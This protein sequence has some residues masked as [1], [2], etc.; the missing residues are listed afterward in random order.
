M[1]DY[2]KGTRMK[3]IFQY[4]QD[5]QQ[6]YLE[7]LFTFLRCKSVSSYNDGIKE[8]AQLL[9]EIM[10]KSGIQTAIYPTQGN[11]VVY[12]EIIEDSAL[13]TMLIYGHY[14]VQPPEPLD[15]WN[16]PPFEPTI[17][18]GK[19]YCRGVSDDKSQLYTHIKA[20][21][22]WKKTKGRYPVNVKFLFEGEEEI[23]SPNL[24]PFVESHKELLSCDVCFYS[25]S[26]FHENGKPQINL[27]VKGLCYVEITIE[28]AKTDMHSMM[29]TSIQN[30]AWRLVQLLN[31]MYDSEG[32][33][34]IEGFYD[35]VRPIS[36]LEIEAVNKIPV[37]EKELCEVYGVREFIHGPHSKNFY[38]NL[39]F[40]PT[41]N[42]SGLTSGY[43]GPG[44]KTVLPRQASVKIDMRL[45][46]DQDPEKILKALRLHLNRHGFED[47]KMTHYGMVMP[48]R[49]RIDHLYVS[50]AVNAVK[51][52]FEEEP[53]LFPGIGGVAPDFVFTG[54]INVPTIVIPYAA[55]DQKNHAPNESM[56][57]DGFIKGL[58]TSAALPYYLAQIGRKGKQE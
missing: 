42:I 28:N 19:I 49:T 58:R 30:P 10:E 39:I 14:D 11:P 47:A 9:S 21:E 23:G 22:A 20:V 36:N 57:M 3:E 29:A 55:A 35:D 34:C 18:E 37:N 53:I 7:E 24:L 27:G 43:T 1:I 32:H 56:V 26:H 8:C 33:I 31:T 46:P 4:I 54:H 41:C 52:G 50:A 6:E 45:V 25:D 17:R 38:Y 48:S 13:P 2:Q 40:E 16:S 44:S 15:E 51:L 12:G 5:K